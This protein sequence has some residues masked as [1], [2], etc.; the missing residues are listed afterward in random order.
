MNLNT[1]TA[2][3]QAQL[4]HRMNTSLIGDTVQLGFTMSDAQ[5]RDVNFKNQFSE[6]ELHGFVLD[7]TPSQLLV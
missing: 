3:Q 4:W 7:V 2:V 5:M 1:P 6:I